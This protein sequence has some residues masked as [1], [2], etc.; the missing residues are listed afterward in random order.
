MNKHLGQECKYQPVKC[1]F[2]KYGCKSNLLRH[3]VDDHLKNM[4]LDHLNTCLSALKKSEEEAES[5][6]N[7]IGQLQKEKAILKSGIEHLSVLKPK[8]QWNQLSRSDIPFLLPSTMHDKSAKRIAF[9]T[10]EPNNIIGIK[11]RLTGFGS[12]FSN[13]EKSSDSQVFALLIAD[14]PVHSILS[15]FSDVP[16][17]FEVSVLKMGNPD[18]AGVCIGFIDENYNIKNE[19]PLGLSPG[20]YGFNVLQQRIYGAGCDPFKPC[21]GT[22]RVTGIFGCGWDYK[23]GVIFFVTDGFCAGTHFSKVNGPLSPAVTLTS[24]GIEI[25]VNF[26]AT[27]FSWDVSKFWKPFRQLEMDFEKCLVERKCT[28]TVTGSDY[29]P[30][31]MFQCKTCHLEGNLGMCEVCVSVCHVG[32]A[33]TSARLTPFFCD[34]G[35]LTKGKQKNICKCIDI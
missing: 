25:S 2:E 17:Y 15:N 31:L 32:H 1:P 10:G 19:K 5:F 13:N 34:C 21:Y 29:V 22:P 35:E 23:Q 26:G 28:Y 27:P 18:E 9:T 11:S 6:I 14:K 12:L 20:S 3:E 8:L 24:H 16:F 30:Q 4:A 7:T 33:I